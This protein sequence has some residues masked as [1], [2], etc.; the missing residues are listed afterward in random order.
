MC[1]CVI[2]TVWNHFQNSVNEFD[3]IFREFLYLFKQKILTSTII[4][5]MDFDYGSYLKNM[6]KLTGLKVSD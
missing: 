6:T 4:D 1:V 3:G 5:F 2:S